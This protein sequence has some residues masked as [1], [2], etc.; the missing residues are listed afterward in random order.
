MITNRLSINLLYPWYHTKND[1]FACVLEKDIKAALRTIQ[2]KLQML[3]YAK[4]LLLQIIIS[5]EI[6]CNNFIDVQLC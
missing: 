1:L 6:V 4:I 3:V 2:C 5:I